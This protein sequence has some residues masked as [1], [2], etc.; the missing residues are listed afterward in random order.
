MLLKEPAEHS[1]QEEDP[2]AL[3]YEPWAQSVQLEEA[4][5]EIAPAG[6]S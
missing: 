6:Q 4:F 2:A 5:A 1:L 3:A